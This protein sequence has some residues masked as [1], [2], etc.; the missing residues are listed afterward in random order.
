MAQFTL[1]KYRSFFYILYL[2]LIFPKATITHYF[3]F[4][5]ILFSCLWSTP[6]IVST[7]DNKSTHPVSALVMLLLSPG[8]AVSSPL[9]PTMPRSDHYDS[10]TP[11][12]HRSS[13][14]KAEG[15]LQSQLA[16]Y[17]KSHSPRPQST[18]I[19][20]SDT[21]HYITTF[22]VSSTLFIMGSLHSNGDIVGYPWSEVRE[23][24]RENR[25]II[26][27]SVCKDCGFKQ[28]EVMTRSVP[29]IELQKQKF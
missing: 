28:C 29:L 12:D 9:L 25:Y 7:P 11:K 18:P 19:K 15:K 4:F 5:L 3:F 16:E 8:E 22:V 27:V 17:T 6:A 26:K 20:V 13:D 24:A 23:E 2:K 21:I 14:R 1:I 10:S